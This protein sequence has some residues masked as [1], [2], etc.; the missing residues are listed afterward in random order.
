[1]E[2][3]VLFMI[4]HEQRPLYPTKITPTH[5]S[6]LREAQG[7]QISFL[8]FPAMEV[9]RRSGCSTPSSLEGSQLSTN[10]QQSISNSLSF[11]LSSEKRPPENLY[12]PDGHGNSPDCIKLRIKW[13]E[14]QDRIELLE[15]ELFRIVPC[16]LPR[17]L[18]HQ[19]ENQSR[20]IR[21][22]AIETPNKLQP[23]MNLENQ[24]ETPKN[25]HP[26]NQSYTYRGL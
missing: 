14:Y 8:T 20:S 2:P 24:I 9:E 17:C 23:L 21:S 11:N 19:N 1:M 13:R 10:S 4:R 15:D 3:R 6:T 25:L 7:W 22:S 26:S 18:V 12:T 16:P 5:R